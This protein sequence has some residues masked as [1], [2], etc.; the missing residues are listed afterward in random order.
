MDE[1]GGAAAR[2]HGGR[3]GEAPRAL[4]VE[5]ATRAPVNG[6][7]LLALAVSGIYSILQ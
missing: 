6:S 1:G 7:I 5:G 4:L 3:E 2:P